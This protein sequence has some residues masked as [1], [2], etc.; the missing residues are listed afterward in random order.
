MS[1]SHIQESHNNKNEE[2]QENQIKGAHW[3]L[4]ISHNSH[5]LKSF[6]FKHHAFKSLLWYESEVNNPDDVN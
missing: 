4:L 6:Q 3:I 5:F 2:M 1:Q